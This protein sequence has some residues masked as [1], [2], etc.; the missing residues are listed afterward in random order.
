MADVGDIVAANVRAE[1]SRRRWT[2][3]QLA[4]LLGWS[5]PT[6]SAVE[7]GKRKLL[8]AELPDLCRVFD[9]PLSRLLIGAQQ[10]DVAVLRLGESI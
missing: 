6:V 10:D 9:V 2:Q 8:V 7:A 4:E 1:R 5:R 3:D